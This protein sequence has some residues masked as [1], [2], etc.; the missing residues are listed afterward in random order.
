[1]HEGVSENV[2][3]NAD[4]HK[5]LKKVTL[6]QEISIYFVES[7]IDGSHL[8]A[9]TLFGPLKQR[10]G[11]VYQS[12]V[13][14]CLLD[15]AEFLLTCGNNDLGIGVVLNFQLSVIP[16]L[17]NVFDILFKKGQHKE[18]IQLLQRSKV[19]T[20]IQCYSDKLTRI[21]CCMMTTLGINLFK[22]ASND[23]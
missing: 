7:K 12:I 11:N 9:H 16:I 15:L 22:D 13:T 19:T 1:M 21:C 5:Y 6:Q 17:T 10:S 14:E 2:L 20:S 3:T 23:M 8:K 4:I 18:I